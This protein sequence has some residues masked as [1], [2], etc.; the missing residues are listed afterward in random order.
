ME[1]GTT[2]QQL[3]LS[4]DLADV[5]IVNNGPLEALHRRVEELL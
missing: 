3:R 5:T 1:G 2:G 4:L